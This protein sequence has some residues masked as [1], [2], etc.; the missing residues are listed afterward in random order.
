MKTIAVPLTG[1]RGYEIHVGARLEGLGR[2]L[3]GRVAGRRA[4]VVSSAP[5]ARLYGPRLLRSLRAAGF[6]PALASVP[7]GE[8]RK[9]LETVR[10]IY[11]ACL[12]AR[13]DRRCPVIALGGGVV[14]D[15]A[16]F[17]A[18][19]YMRGLPLVQC[20]TTL[21]AA[22]DSSIGGKTGVDLPE[23]KNLVGAFHQ[24]RLVWADLSVLKTLP[25]K[26]W[27]T[28][29]AEVVK[30]GLIADA[31]LANRLEALT[32]SNLRGKPALLEDIVARCA[33]IKADVV[34]RDERETRGLRE[35]LNLGHTFGH[36]VEAVT[37]YKAYTHGEA[38]SIGM[39][40]AARLAAR[41]GLAPAPLAARTEILLARWGLPVRAR[42]APPRKKLLAAMSRDKKNRAGKFRF[43]VPT[44]WGRVRSGVEATP[45]VLDKVLTEVGL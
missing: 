22:V 26:E 42:R 1:G 6:A 32:L 41:L 16:G 2:T 3:R 23:G 36:A 11:A 12:A 19:T 13:L 43:V 17:A 18:A 45:D 44:A 8:S 24:P 31:E 25:E 35:I 10:K 29:M 30:Y 7:A 28:G 27:R 9:N 15:A 39:A 37:G 40:A 33:A 38:I 4:L 14:G 34:A 20:P 21:L 5:M